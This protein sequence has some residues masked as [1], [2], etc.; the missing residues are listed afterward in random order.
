MARILVV[1][2]DG[3]IGSAL[4]AAFA[5]RGDA[6]V[7]TSRRT[8]IGAPLLDLAAPAATWP[9]LS[10]DVAFLC[11]AQ[12]RLAECEA[13]PVGSERV[14]VDAPVDLAG[15]L[16]RG[17]AWVCALSTTAVFDGA[18]P[19]YAPAD[20]PRPRSRY[21]EQK[22]R[23]ERGVLEAAD[24]RACIVRLGKVVSDRTPLFQAWAQSLRAGVAVQAFEDVTLAPVAIESV[25]DLLLRIADARAAG[26]VHFTAAGEMTY[27]DAARELARTVGADLALVT[28]VPAPT[29]PRWPRHATLDSRATGATF[30]VRVP[31]PEWALRRHR[32]EPNDDAS[33]AR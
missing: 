12:T 30:G 32:C 26:I 23:M 27:R 20:A 7:A 16:H 29:Q 8:G 21:G 1:G 3:A 4:A 25:V 28:G 33:G 19:D 10:G 6:V 22:V 9:Q 5:R 24:G 15:S 18:R 17:G 14:N 13:D 11:A 2:G 31:P